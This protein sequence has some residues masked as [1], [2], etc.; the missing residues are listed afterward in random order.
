MTEQEQREYNLNHALAV[1][2][3][4]GGCAVNVPLPRRPGAGLEKKNA[5]DTRPYYGALGGVY[6][7]VVKDVLV[8]A[9]RRPVLLKAENCDGFTILTLMIDKR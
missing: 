9:Q 8:L 5:R 7:E 3:D 6:C 2:D 1:H 4:D